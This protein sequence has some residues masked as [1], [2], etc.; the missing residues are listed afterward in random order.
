MPGGRPLKFKSEKEFV[1]YLCLNIDA[2]IKDFYDEE[3]AE[4][5]RNVSVQFRVFGA[6]KPSIDLTVTTKSGKQIGIE[7]K[8]PKQPYH[9]TS[10]AVSQLL[11]YA[12]LAEE[13]GRPFDELAI[14]TSDRH[15][16]GCKVIK[17]Y[18]LPIRVFYVDREKHGELGI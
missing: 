12:V 15:N 6:N 9:E 16:I 13:V 11:A 7:C 8:N 2:V 10:R 4:V 5:K 18:N 14:I 17:K 3:V 1:D